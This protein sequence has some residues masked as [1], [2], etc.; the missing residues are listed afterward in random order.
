MDRKDRLA[1]VALATAALHLRLSFEQLIAIGTVEDQRLSY[2]RSPQSLLVRSD[3][4]NVLTLSALP[5]RAQQ[6]RR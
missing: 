4:E 2:S 5:A 1:L 6:L 3:R